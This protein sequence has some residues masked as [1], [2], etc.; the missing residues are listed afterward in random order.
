MKEICKAL[1]A[2]ILLIQTPASLRPDKL[3]DTRNFFRKISRECLVVAWETRGPSWEASSIREKL[4]ETLRELDVPHATDP[5]R[6]LP[7][8]TSDVAYFR[9]HGLGKRL[10]YYQYADE[11]LKRLRELVKPLEA[12]GKEVYVLLNNLAMFDDGIRFMHFIET[13]RFPS[14][15]GAVG[16]ESVKSVVQK[17]RYPTT[18]SLLSKRLGWRL[19]ELEE[20][21]YTR[22]DEL[23]KNAL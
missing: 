5:L 16:L 22:E 8:Y 7:V 14:L 11:E 19:V 3:G 4:A 1:K 15:T 23:L 2:R 20:G 6:A 9:L 12:E 10:Y 17:T 13:G 18:K 21:K